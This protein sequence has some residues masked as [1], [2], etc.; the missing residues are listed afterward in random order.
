M[1]E[2]T[3]KNEHQKYFNRIDKT[4]EQDLIKNQNKEIL[5]RFLSKIQKE[6]KYYSQGPTINSIFTKVEQ[7]KINPLDS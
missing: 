4:I 6:D 3:L 5:N 1:V 7:K 2:K